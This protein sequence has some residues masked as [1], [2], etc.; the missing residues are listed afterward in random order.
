[1][2]LHWRL[3]DILDLEFFL[4]QEQ[5]DKKN[6][7]QE[8]ELQQRDRKLA[9]RAEAFYEQMSVGDQH[10]DK[11]N[12]RNT[13]NTKKFENYLLS[14]WLQER[15]R[16][17]DN[18]IRLPGQILTEVLGIFSCLFFVIGLLIGGIMAWSFL[19]Y[20]GEVPV[21]VSMYMVLFVVTQIILLALMPFS[22]LISRLRGRRWL[23]LTC[24]LIG[25]GVTW[26]SDKI[27]RQALL[28]GEQRQWH[29]TFGGFLR[30]HKKIY[31]SLF[32]LPFFRIIQLFAIGFNLGLLAATLLKVTITDIAFGWQSTLSQSAEIVYALV[33]IIAWPWSW[34]MPAG[35]GHPDLDQIS[36]SHLILKEGI[37]HLVSDDLVSW[38]PFLC[39]AILVYGLLPRVFLFLSAWLTERTMLSR[40]R[41][42]SALHQQVIRRMCTPVIDTEA[43]CPDNISSLSPPGQLTPV[44]PESQVTAAVII[45]TD[46][47][48]SLIPDELYDDCQPELFARLLRECLHIE[49]G[50]ILRLDDD[51]DIELLVQKIKNELPENH[52]ILLL[53][54]AWQPPIEEFFTFLKKLREQIGDKIM[55]T[56]CLIGRPKRESI[57][58]PVRAGEYG[59]WQQKLAAL[60]DP[61]LQCVCLVNGYE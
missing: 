6:L 11:G 55:V 24:N 27:R 17:S 58:T 59:V 34:L 52:T 40:L 43:A 22:W 57:F 46:Q 30:R 35:L 26:L 60:G 48:L 13:K 12:K 49:P 18:E 1:M 33:K 16:Q 29:G 61:W 31:G 32:I 54:E 3:S 2:K 23:P 4:N 21:N 37:Y 41:F 47:I 7:K 10:K 36:G 38:W 39:M 25:N 44:P 20:L 45:A 19:T 9:L 56:I 42:D 50:Q 53:Q 51:L 14:I 28:G 15:R 8:K 5:I